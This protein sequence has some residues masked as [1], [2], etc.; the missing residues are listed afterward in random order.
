MAKA[1]AH[2]QSEMPFGAWGMVSGKPPLIAEKSILNM[3]KKE[4]ELGTV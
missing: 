3:C 1:V 2:L 4:G